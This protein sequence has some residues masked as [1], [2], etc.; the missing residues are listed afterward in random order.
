MDILASLGF[1][2]FAIAVAWGALYFLKRARSRVWMHWTAFVFA[3][4][5]GLLAMGSWLTDLLAWGTGFVPYLSGILLFVGLVIVFID[6]IDKRPD[7]LALICAMII[8]SVVAAG[9]GQLQNAWDQ[10]GEN[11]EQVKTTIEQQAE[12]R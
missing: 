12:G 11:A 9:V 1:L 7:R 10:V 3:C 6:L 8:P 5:A 4:V 2:G